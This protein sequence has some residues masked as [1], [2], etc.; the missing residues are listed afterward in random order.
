[1]DHIL[2]QDHAVE[3]LRHQLSSGKGHHALIFHGPMGVGKF[4]TAL[5]YAQLL[6]CH[7]ESSTETPRT[8]ACGRCD[9]CRL[10]RAVDV[11]D[12]DDGEDELAALTTAHP[13]LHIVRKELAM[14]SE[15]PK[16]RQQKQRVI[17]VDVLRSELVGPAG[18][19]PKLRHGKVFIIDEAELMNAS[20]QNTILKTLEEPPPGTTIILVT[21]H[22][23]RL[24]PTVRSR[25]LRVFFSPLPDEVV[26]QW[27]QQHM[28]GLTASQRQ[29]L[30]AFADGSLGRAELIR[31]Y[32]LLTWYD[33]IPPALD[34]AAQGHFT[35][36]LGQSIHSLVD[37]FASE[38]VKTHTNAS[39][40]AANHQAVDLMLALIASHARKRL[41]EI[42]AEHPSNQSEVF[43]DRLGPWLAVIDATT[44]AQRMI[45]SNVN[46]R[47]VCEHLAVSVMNALVGVVK[48]TII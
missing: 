11:L 2:G 34:R 33:T 18:L 15:D 26:A 28:E 6:L 8:S 13:D 42:S 25:C 41:V 44:D 22:E 17:P 36:D 39:K 47:M 29:A 40:E 3:L 12:H 30:V 31:R 45:A 1:M 37:G 38:W 24:L 14:F 10:F 27:C 9:S 43:R 46:M 7:E 20:G 5:A 4:T 21:S 19:A 32:G 23:D 16:V 48:C 35:P